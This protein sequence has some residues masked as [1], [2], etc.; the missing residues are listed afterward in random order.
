MLISCVKVDVGLVA[1]EVNTLQTL[2]HAA[3]LIRRVQ[4]TG[5]WLRVP[6]IEC[7]LKKKVVIA[8]STQN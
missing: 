7:D 2:N 6:A 4:T 8:N 3:E 1:F 5:N